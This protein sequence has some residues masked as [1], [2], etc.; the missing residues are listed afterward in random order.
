MSF[1]G[2]WQVV[3]ANGHLNEFQYCWGNEEIDEAI[4]RGD[5]K[6]DDCGA[7]IIL[8]NIVDD[9]NCDAIGEMKIE[10]NVMI[11]GQSYTRIEDPDTGNY[12][13]IPYKAPAG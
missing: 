10:E 13:L 4:P 1:E 6:C 11:E 8:H 5:A 7:L 12:I 9:T 3:C 2:F